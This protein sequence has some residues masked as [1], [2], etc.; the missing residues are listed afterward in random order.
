MFP[1]LSQSLVSR[2]NGRGGNNLEGDDD[3]GGDDGG[4][5]GDVGDVGGGGG[6]DD[7]GG[8][9]DEVG[10]ILR[11]MINSDCIWTYSNLACQ[12]AR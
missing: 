8:D 9:D 4:D 10:T 3:D 7:D 5:D 12:G 11:K 6:D 2:V 1:F